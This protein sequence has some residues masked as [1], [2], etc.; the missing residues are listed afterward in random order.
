[1]P[2]TNP[3]PRRVK[4]VRHGPDQTIHLPRDLEL[5]GNTA[6]LRVED[7]RLVIEAE[8]IPA[9]GSPNAR[10]LALLAT[11]KPLAPEDRMPEIPDPPPEPVDL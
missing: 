11:L 5:P 4:L 3:A 2:D 7:G 10:L 8:A 9:E 6:L 1:M